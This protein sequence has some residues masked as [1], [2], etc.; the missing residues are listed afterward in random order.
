M[1]GMLFSIRSFVSKMSPLDM[2]A[3][4]VGMLRG[5]GLAL[6]IWGGGN[7]LEWKGHLAPREGKLNPERECQSCKERWWGKSDD[8]EVGSGGQ[9]WR[10][11]NG[12][13]GRCLLNQA[14]TNMFKEKG[15][16]LEMTRSFFLGGFCSH[17]LTS[18]SSL[19]EGWFSGLPN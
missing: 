10:R 15:I 3:E 11:G 14:P 4:S 13:W 16:D 17:S 2:Y 1:Y 7:F 19:Q 6:G 9:M 18:S 5:K 12:A 8:R